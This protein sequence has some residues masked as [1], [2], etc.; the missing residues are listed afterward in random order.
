MINHFTSQGLF[1]LN[2]YWQNLPVIV[3]GS[4]LGVDVT[5]EDPDKLLDG[6]VEVEA[7]LVVGRSSEDDGLRS[8]EL[9]LVDEVFV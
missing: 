6:V 4:S 7:E 8:L 9:Y 1:S 3:A 5:L 2:S